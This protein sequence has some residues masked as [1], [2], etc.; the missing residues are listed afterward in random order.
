MDSSTNGEHSYRLEFSGVIRQ[1]F[2]KLLRQA[3]WEGRGPQFREAMRIIF[4]RLASDPK[5]LGEPLYRL[6]NLRL[7][8]RQVAV[9]PLVVDFAVH[10]DYPLV[11]IKTVA[12]LPDE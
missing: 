9:R 3:V 10:D 8:V 1:E 12:L 5:E 11:F 2:R 6:T 7:Q 4:H